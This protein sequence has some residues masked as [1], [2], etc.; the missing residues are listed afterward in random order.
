MSASAGVLRLEAWRDQH[1]VLHRALR[2]LGPRS[3]G[4]HDLLD[5]NQSDARD[6]AAII[7]RLG[8]FPIAVHGVR[9]DGS[10]TCDRRD[11]GAVGK[12]P[13]EAAWQKRAL[14]L[15]QL[16]GMLRERWELNLGWRMGPQPGGFVLVAIDVDGPRSLLEPVEAE[17]GPMPLTLTA[18]TAR[19]CHLLYRVPPDQT[20]R[21]RVRLAP[22]VDVRAAGGMIVVS[23]SNHA[24]GARYRWTVA[25]EP[26]GLS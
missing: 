21:N 13:V 4:W 5:A 6:A 7:A 14:N 11:C 20:L 24:S 17:H 9:R 18:T 1:G 2:P 23:P 26:E 15:K 10:C 3:R 16:D 22:G 12:H 19:G 8:G 25:R